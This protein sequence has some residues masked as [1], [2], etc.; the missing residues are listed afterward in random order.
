VS[1]P[2]TR[3]LVPGPEV[4]IATHRAKAGQRVCLIGHSTS[5]FVFACAHRDLLIGEAVLVDGLVVGEPIPAA[6][7]P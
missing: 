2:N 3:D 1:Y 6:V 7:K 4:F 5:I